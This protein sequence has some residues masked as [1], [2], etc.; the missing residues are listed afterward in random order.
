M[1]TRRFSIKRFIL[2]LYIGF[3]G[4]FG[5]GGGSMCYGGGIIERRKLFRHFQLSNCFSTFFSFLLYCWSSCYRSSNWW[6]FSLFWDWLLILT[7]FALFI[8]KFNLSNGGGLLFFYD[9]TLSFFF[10]SIGLMG[11]IDL[12]L[13]FVDLFLLKFPNDDES[14]LWSLSWSVVFGIL[15]S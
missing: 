14:T 5:G 1:L 2:C 9:F 11:I 8:G 12:D 13:Q 10:K 4:T 3:L 7:D 6:N 15:V